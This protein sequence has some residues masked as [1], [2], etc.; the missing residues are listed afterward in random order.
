MFTT[1]VYIREN[2]SAALI[3]VDPGKWRMFICNRKIKIGPLQ[4][5]SSGFNVYGK[6]PSVNGWENAAWQQMN[7]IRNEAVDTHVLVTYLNSFLETKRLMLLFGG[8]PNQNL[9]MT[10]DLKKAIDEITNMGLMWPAATR[11]FFRKVSLPPCLKGCQ[12]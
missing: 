9:R 6:H 1:T 5:A 12:T 2:G 10:A 11:L 3:S 4:D 7:I 8:I